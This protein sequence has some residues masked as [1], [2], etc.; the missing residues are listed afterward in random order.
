MG[1]LYVALAP[2]L[3][4]LRPLLRERRR[5]RG[6]ERTGAGGGG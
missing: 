2:L 4:A 6:A 1:V 5:W 3:L